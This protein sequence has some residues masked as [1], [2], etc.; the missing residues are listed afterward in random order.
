MGLKM[1]IELQLSGQLKQ[2]LQMK[3]TPAMLQSMEV[4]QMPLMALEQK[5]FSELSSNP[6]LE[7]DLSETVEEAPL[8]GSSDDE[9]YTEKVLEISPEKTS[10]SFE[11]LE[12]LGSDYNNYISGDEPYRPLSKSDEDPKQE[13]LLNTADIKISLQEYL[14]DQWRL[15]KEDEDVLDA[16]EYI[17]RMLDKRGYLNSSLE[18]IADN[19]QYSID[20]ITIAYD[21]VKQ[22][23]PAGVGARTIRECLLLQIHQDDE[24]P[25]IV[26]QIIETHY[27]T[28]LDNHLPQLAK[29]LNCTIED[30]NSAI[31]YLSRLDTS[32]GLL[33]GTNLDNAPVKVDVIVEEAE[34]DGEY[35]VRLA[36]GGLPALTVSDY[37]EKMASDKTVAG[38]TR[39]YLQENIRS[40]RWLI[41]AIAQRKETLLKIS[42]YIVNRQKTFFTEGRLGLKPLSMQEIADYIGVH[43]AT[44]SRA[45][46]GKYALCPNGIIALREFFNSGKLESSED[47]GEEMGAEY[48]KETLRQVIEEENKSKPLSD[49]KLMSEMENKGIKV[50]RR[51]IAKY[52]E[53]LG[54][55]SARM[56]KKFQ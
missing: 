33:F 21:L 2:E 3:L 48:V 32:P 14:L 22:L 55:P 49:E 53:Q 6:V 54:I 29:K 17:I 9:N 16:G 34:D 11:R 23:E 38:E 25:E 47:D 20:V 52:R 41:D 13:A 45:V 50:A 39:K 42:A 30:V 8:S 18:E 15:L 28:L 36:S 37:Y 4:L 5:V 46:S 27:Q 1:A 44:V 43:T 35:T 24:A 19:S 31:K 12:N 51:T 56:R 7:I 26:E 40:A 10:D